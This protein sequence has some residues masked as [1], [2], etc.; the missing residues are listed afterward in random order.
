MS[1]EADSPFAPALGGDSDSE[2][3]TD[4]RGTLP[5]DAGSAFRFVLLGLRTGPGGGVTN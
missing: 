1:R 5:P 2:A 3:M 4:R